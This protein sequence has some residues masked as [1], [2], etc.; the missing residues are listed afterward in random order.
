MSRFGIND[1]IKFD[2]AVERASV[3]KSLSEQKKNRAGGGVVHKSVKLSGGAP[4]W[5]R[6]SRPSKYSLPRK[7]GER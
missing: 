5:L 1:R 7:K 3:L 2:M 6:T 4:S